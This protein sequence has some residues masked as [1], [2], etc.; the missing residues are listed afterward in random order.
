MF[1]ELD[2]SSTSA[3]GETTS[4]GHS[5]TSIFDIFQPGDNQL[6]PGLL[7]GQSAHAT[8]PAQTHVGGFGSVTPTDSSTATAASV[9]QNFGLLTTS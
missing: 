1:V 7:D 4:E 3:D 2:A 9:R 8:A 6:G 5:S